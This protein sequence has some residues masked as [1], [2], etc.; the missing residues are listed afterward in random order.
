MKKKIIIVLAVILI[1]VLGVG[2]LFISRNHSKNSSASQKWIKTAIMKPEENTLQPAGYITVTWKNAKQ[3]GMVKNY[4][5]Y[6]DN[7]KVI[8][9]KKTTYECHIS[10][11]SK[12]KI[13]V[14]VSF[15]NGIA[16]RTK[17]HTFYVNKKGLCMNTEMAYN[18]DAQKWGA[19]WYYNWAIPEFTSES[20]KKIQFVPMFWSK[21]DTNDIVASKL[22]KRG[23]KYLLTFNE[24][25]LAEQCD[26]TVEEAIEGMRD[27]QNTGLLVGSPATARCPVWS[28]TWFTS[29]MNRMKYEKMDVDFI[30]FHHYWNWYDEG[31]ADAFLKL[32]DQTYQ[33]YK[34]PIWVTEFAINGYKGKTKEEQEGIKQ[35]MTDV[36]KGMDERE[37]VERYAWFPYS[38]TDKISPGSALLTYF[39]A[40]ETELGKT[41]QQLG[42]PE[43]Y[44]APINNFDE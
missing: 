8:T 33:M 15:Y 14:E 17:E 29:F 26:L 34:K 28:T 35:Y 38:T 44:V 2:V 25:D 13:S 18:V 31:A 40:K 43:G 37:F 30:A 27:F 19:S 4:T 36:I 39:S 10:D 3:L 21:Y 23:Y 5:V 41:Y 22:K 20:F 12:H 7:K 9:T 11:V 42:M 6:L 16:I 32:L 1:I 24:P